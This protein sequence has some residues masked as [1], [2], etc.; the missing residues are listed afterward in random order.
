LHLQMS[1][2]SEDSMAQDLEDC[3]KLKIDVLVLAY[4]VLT[5]SMIFFLTLSEEVI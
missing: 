2:V 5:E 3:G 4:S 1:V